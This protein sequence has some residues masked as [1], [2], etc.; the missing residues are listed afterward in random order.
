[1]R[2]RPAMQPERASVVDEVATSH[3]MLTRNSLGGKEIANCA[4]V[5]A[6]N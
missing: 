3:V 4:A 2:G 5:W 1:M 6:L